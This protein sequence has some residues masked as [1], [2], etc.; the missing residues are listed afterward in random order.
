M[1]VGRGTV[2][3]GGA[4]ADDE[5]DTMGPIDYVVVEFPGSR[6]TG[7]AM[8][9]LVDLVDRGIIRILDLVFVKKGQDGSVRGM[10]VADLDGDERLDLAVFEGASSG[11]ISEEDIAEAGAVLEPGSSAGILV[12]ENVWAAPFAAALRRAGGQLVASGRIP[13]QAMLAALEAAEAA[14]GRL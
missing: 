2:P 13:V 9:L 6:M 8:P 10:V 3:A 1:A 5:L 11:I 12:Y 14:E 4:A 7:E